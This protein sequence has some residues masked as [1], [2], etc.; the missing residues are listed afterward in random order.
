MITPAQAKAKFGE[1]GVSEGTYM[2]VWT[3]PADIRSALAH[4]RFSALGT[5]GFPS[6]IY[7]NK[8]LKISLEQALRNVIARGLSAEMKTW[9][10]CYI[11]R[12]ARGL[13]SWSLHAWGLAIDTNAATNRLGA[14]P[15]LSQGFVRCFTDAGLDWGGK[16]SRPDG[17]HFQLASFGG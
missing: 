11:I 15:T 6:K 7:M 9:D 2:L 8:S 17:M 3:V 12:N 10:G 16:W 14:P 13:S 1:P 4:V 5:T